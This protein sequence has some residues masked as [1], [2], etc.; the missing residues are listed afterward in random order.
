MPEGT[1]IKIK[2]LTPDQLEDYLDFFD[3][4][5]FSDGSPFY[6]CYCS[7]FN[8]SRE[9]IQQ[10]F[11]RQAEINGGG[12]DGWKKALR[13]SAVHMVKNGEIQ[14]YLAYE[15]DL[16]VGWCNANDRLNYCRVGEFD[17]SAVPPDE[18]CDNCQCRG[19]V[20]SVVCFEIAPEYRGKGI[21]TLLLET[22]C[23]DALSEG[24]MYVE[25]YPATDEGLQGLAFTGPK[26][27]YEK[28]GFKV[29]AQKGG[30]LVM[31]KQLDR[32]IAACGNDCSA[33]PRYVAHPY[34]KTDGELRYT[35]ELWMKIGY[36]DHLVTNEEISCTGCKPENRCRYHV[37]RC[38]KEKGISSCAQCEL[39]PCDNMKK[40]FEVTKSFEPDCRRACTEEEYNQLKK[41]FFEKELN[42]KK[43]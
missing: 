4:R 20:K 24:Y 15:D 43:L 30:I 1:M 18:P 39:Y 40:C 25:A 41:A 17:L 14:G 23:R 38:C 5:A 10:E 21:A 37:V 32:I 11:F 34:E 3:H 8:M 42:L 19:Q 27:L 28:A 29:T 16:A 31:R 33:C 36:R 9:R 6:P 26:R 12:N 13:D 22:V 7:A 2:K 35:A